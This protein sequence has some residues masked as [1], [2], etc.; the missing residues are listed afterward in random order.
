MNAGLKVIEGVTWFGSDHHFGHENIIRY[1][2]RPWPANPEGVEAM[3]A[4]MI[5][6]H[7]EVAGKDDVY[8]HLGDLVLSARWLEQTAAMNGRKMIIPGNHDGCWPHA[9][10]P[11]KI[12][13]A[14]VM[15][16]A[17]GW[18][19]LGEQAEVI[20]PG[21]GR[22]L[23]CHLPYEGDSREK[24]GGVDRYKEFR[25]AWLGAPQI[26]GHVHDAWREKEIARPGH[27]MRMLNVGVDVWDFA[28]VAVSAVEKWV[29]G[30]DDGNEESL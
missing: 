20:L 27:T 30:H 8:L 29:N 5:Q 18:E 3:N 23:A 10:K 24:S 14:R 26:C 17:A 21:G 28:P 25:P 19:V 4:E 1:C 13:A 6:R 12:P 15:Y 2:S 16:E 22:V 11:A 7:N 9:R